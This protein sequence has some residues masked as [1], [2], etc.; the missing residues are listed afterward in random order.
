MTFQGSGGGGGL[1][2]K[3]FDRG[4]R[5]RGGGC[6]YGSEVENGIPMERG[7]IKK[8]GFVAGVG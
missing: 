2:L 3:G 7:G 1:E 5:V 8:E 6:R 4:L